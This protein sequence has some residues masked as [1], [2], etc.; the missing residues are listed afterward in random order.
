MLVSWQEAA[1]DVPV[2]SFIIFLSQA[3][4]QQQSAAPADG[5]RYERPL[6]LQQ[7]R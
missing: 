3:Q 6:R 4:R 2:M 5:L 1:I 7:Y